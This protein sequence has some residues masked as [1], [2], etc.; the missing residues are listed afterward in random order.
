MLGRIWSWVGGRDEPERT[1]K[2]ERL[3]VFEPLEPRVLLDADCAGVQPLIFLEAPV[4][5]QA[6]V[7][8]LPG[9]ITPPEETALSPTLSFELIAPSDAALPA[10]D[11]DENDSVHD[12]VPY[13]ADGQSAG[14]QLELAAGGSSAEVDVVTGSA[15]S[16]SLV[17]S[18]LIAGVESCDSA[19]ISQKETAGLNIPGGQTDSVPAAQALPIEIRG[20]PAPSVDSLT[21]LPE[22]TYE[23]EA[24]LSASAEVAG[25]STP[26]APN[27]PGLRL[28]DPDISNWRG[29]IIYLDFDGAQN[30]TYH[31]PVTVGPFDV[32]AFQAPDELAG[33]ERTIIGEVLTQVRRTF[34]NS[35]IIFTT[36]KPSAHQPYS[37]IYIGGDDSAFIE[38]GSFFGLAETVD[39]GNHDQDDI[40]LIFPSRRSVPIAEPCELTGPIIS[41]ATHEVGHL[42]GYEHT[43]PIDDS[44]TEAFSGVQEVATGAVVT[45]IKVY[46]QRNSTWAW[47]ILWNSSGGWQ[48]EGSGSKYVYIDPGTSVQ[49]RVAGGGGSY[50]YVYQ[51]MTT[52]QGNESSGEVSQIYHDFSSLESTEFQATLISPV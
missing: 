28:V 1:A 27:L 10:P 41:G 47:V 19:A 31:G 51:L 18:S 12:A 17:R 24:F 5:E 37:T 33:Q 4:H 32:P 6:I 52:N 22:T 44:Y 30:I 20:P 38:Y 49:I 35:G 23:E 3:P 50:P 29:Q 43:V 45:S 15:A 46:R 26:I 25:V 11:Q 40:A 9:Q 42:L 48:G 14:D 2:A 34:A 7:I 16:Q 36:E 21:A 39:I 13:D 8:D